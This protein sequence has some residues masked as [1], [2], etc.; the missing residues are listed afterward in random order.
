LATQ[1][2][3]GGLNWVQMFAT[4]AKEQKT[5]Q[6]EAD[7]SKSLR[8]DIGNIAIAN[9]RL[10]LEDQV[11]EMPIHLTVNLAAN[12][13]NFSLLADN[14]MPF[15]SNINLESG[16]KIDLQGDVQVFPSLALNSTVIISACATLFKS[17][18][19]H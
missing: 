11:P 17:I 3:Q 16:G 5:Q 9:T 1:N 13:Q 19:V 6:V 2:K 7:N 14:H 18:C 10:E 4:P 12:L 8:L 15:T